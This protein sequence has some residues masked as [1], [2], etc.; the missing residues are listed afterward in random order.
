M[1]PATKIKQAF[2]FYHHLSP[3]LAFEWQAAK[4]EFRQEGVVRISDLEP[5]CQKH[6][7]T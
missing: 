4:P 1:L 7:Y 6:R 3:I 5:V 2:H